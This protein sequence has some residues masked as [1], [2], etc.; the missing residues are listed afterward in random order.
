MNIYAKEG[1]KITV[2]EETINYG[3]NHHKE[4]ANK[5]LKVGEVYT[6]DHTEVGGWHTDVYIKE[7]PNIAFNS[8]HFEDAV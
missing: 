4:M 5:H 8:V 1:H 7:V 2:T 3:Y 6:V